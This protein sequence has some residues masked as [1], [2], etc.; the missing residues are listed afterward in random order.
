MVFAVAVVGIDDDNDV[1]GDCC[2]VWC[3]LRKV[4]RWATVVV[5]LMRVYVTMVCELE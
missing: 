5:L 4:R 1:G 3:C 2:G